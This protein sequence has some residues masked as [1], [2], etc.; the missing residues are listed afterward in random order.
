MVL[1]EIFGLVAFGVITAAIKVVCDDK[2]EEEER[3]QKILRDEYNDYERRKRQEYKSICSYY[4]NIR[5]NAENEYKIAIHD[6]HKKLVKKRKQENRETFNRMMSIYNEQFFEK[7][8]LLSECRRIVSSCE[9]SIGKH[10]NTYIRFKSIK[11]TLISLNEAVYKLE[12][13]LK[14]MEKYKQRFDNTFENDGK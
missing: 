14:Y 9:I 13:Y 10:Q 7:K 1:L 8:K 5:N 3:R 6:Y 2:S 12:A 4:E 11:L